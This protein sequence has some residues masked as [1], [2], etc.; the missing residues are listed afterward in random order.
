M[1]M[2]SATNSTNTERRRFGLWGNLPLS[3][4]L[5]AAFGGLFILALGIALASFWGLN[6]VQ[7]KYED[8]LAT[9]IKIQ[10]VSQELKIAFAAARQAEA[11]FL[12]NRESLGY[13]RA[14]DDYVTK[15]H[16][17]IARVRGLIDEL[18]DLGYIL[19]EKQTDSFI[20]TK[21][22]SDLSFLTTFIDVYE[23]DFG[24]AVDIIEKLEALEF[25]FGREAT[26]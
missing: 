22:D 20:T 5:F 15:N 17:H 11:D 6:R 9:G 18:S 8:S 12:I 1:N 3:R 14:H 10:D 16:Q 23:K 26:G 24:R 7:S 13:K 4:K 21:F 2:T 25:R 19:K